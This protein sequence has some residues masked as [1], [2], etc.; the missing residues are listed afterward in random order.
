MWVYLCS[1]EILL[2]GMLTV[3]RFLARL[4]FAGGSLLCISW[5]ASFISATLDATE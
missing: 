5:E 3:V 4:V 1:A 2:T